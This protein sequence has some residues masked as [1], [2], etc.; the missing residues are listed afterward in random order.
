MLFTLSGS[1]L[2]HIDLADWVGGRDEIAGWLHIVGL[3]APVWVCAPFDGTTIVC[4][5]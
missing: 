4:P 5:D 2:G 3:D 1:Y